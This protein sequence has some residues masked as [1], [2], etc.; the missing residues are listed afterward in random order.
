MQRHRVLRARG[1]RMSG[2]PRGR[3]TMARSPPWTP[4]S[5]S[6]TSSPPGVAQSRFCRGIAEGKFLGQ[7][8]PECHKV[9]VPPR[10]RARPTAC[11]PTEEVELGNTGTVTTYCVVNVPFQGQSIEIP[12]ICAQILLDGAN[13]AFMGLIQEIPT[14]EVRMGLRVEAV[15]VDPKDLGPSMASVKYFRPIGRARRRLRDLQGVPVSRAEAVPAGAAPVA[16]VSFAQA[17]NV[18]REEHRNEVE[19]L[20]PV[21][22]EVFAERRASPRTTWASSARAAADYLVGGPFSFVG[23]LDAVGA[24]PPM[25][26]SHVEMDGAWALYEAWTV[27]QD[28]GIDTALV[29]SFGR[30]SLGELD[31][32]LALQLDPYYMAPLWPDPVALAALQARA[33]LDA[34]HGDRGRLRRAWP[35]AAGAPPWR[36]PRPRC[37][38]DQRSSELLAEDYVVAPLRRHALPPI[39]DGAAAVVL[40]A[41]DRACELCAAAGVDHRHRPPDRDP[42]P[43]GPG[44]RRRRRRRAAAPGWSAGGG[45]QGTVEVDVAELHA[46]FAH[47]ELILREA[48]GLGDGGRRQPVGW[49][50][51]RQRD[52][53]RP[54]SSASARRPAG[55]WTASAGRAAGPRHLGAVSAAEPGVRSGGRARRRR[56]ECDGRA[57]GGHRG[58]ADPP[59]GQAGRR[60][61]RRAGPRGGAAGPRGRRDGLGRH[62]RGGHRQGPRHV[63][64]CDDARAVPGPGPRGGG[65][66][67]DPGPHGRARWADRRPSWPPTWYVGDPPTGC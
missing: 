2:T 24:W 8:C 19:M 32:V 11:R 23:A 64:G 44:P 22:A 16:V 37:A 35:P 18:R 57:G 26:E 42:R 47:Q 40:A 55:S 46:P 13:I 66:A 54:A 62:R 36:T 28:G 27:L 5:G 61:H 33:L 4:R 45:R 30:S 31:K 43:R 14:D 3:W 58:G 50:P 38:W 6:T 51:G 12:Y 25:R 53:G 49:G 17:D 60:L 41:G 67:D 21:V 10:G 52:H 63:R 59:P 29:Y 15:W 56:E 20:Q 39:T 48:L 9:Y 7:R 34:G 1:E 65:Q